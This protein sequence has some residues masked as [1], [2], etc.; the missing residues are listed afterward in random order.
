MK[1]MKRVW[2][3]RLLGIPV[4]FVASVLG[5]GF[6]TTGASCDPCPNNYHVVC[7]VGCIGDPTI[8]CHK[9]CNL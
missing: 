7:D 3:W 8:C 5:L 6:A 2:R 4:V 1:V 9:E